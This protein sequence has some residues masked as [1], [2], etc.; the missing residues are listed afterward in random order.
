MER[1][2][3]IHSFHDMIHSFC[4]IIHTFRVWYTVSM[5]WHIP[6]HHAIHSFYVSYTD[7]VYQDAR[8]FFVVVFVVVVFWCGVYIGSVYDVVIGVYDTREV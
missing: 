3:T 7:S 4:N 5:I 6:T 8:L 2:N 1:F